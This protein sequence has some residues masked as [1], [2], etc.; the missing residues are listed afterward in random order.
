MFEVFTINT[1]KH[2][3]RVI[4]LITRC[5]FVLKPCNEIGSKTHMDPH[6]LVALSWKPNQ[7]SAIYFTSLGIKFVPAPSNDRVVP[8]WCLCQINRLVDV[9][10][11]S[12]CSGNPSLRGCQLRKPVHTLHA[13]GRFI[14]PWYVPY[15]SV[16]P[17]STI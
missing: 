14:F 3:A 6:V 11:S 5:L 8:F 4:I 7:P 17:W 12:G 13:F 16:K 9:A 2:S 10:F 1:V 15:C